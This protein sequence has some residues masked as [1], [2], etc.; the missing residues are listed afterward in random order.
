M[1]KAEK[2]NKEF[3]DRISKNKK[4]SMSEAV[5]LRCL[6]CMCWDV[7]EVSK[8]TATECPLYLFRSGKNKS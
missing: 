8:C 5:R 2:Q 1:N 7:K 4:V 3:Q 6:D